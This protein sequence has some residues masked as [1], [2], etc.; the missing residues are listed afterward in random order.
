MRKGRGLALTAQG[1]MGSTRLAP[2]FGLIRDA[3]A[4]MRSRDLRQRL[5]VSVE[6]S[7]ATA[8]LVPRLE[9]FRKKNAAIDGADRFLV[10]D[11]GP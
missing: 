2:G 11:R 10:E 6:P 3:V 4:D 1:R 5:I 8:W 7:F 9:R